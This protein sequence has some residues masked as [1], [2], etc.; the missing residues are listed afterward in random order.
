MPTDVMGSAAWNT[1]PGDDA[2]YLAAKCNLLLGRPVLPD[3]LEPVYGKLHFRRPGHMLSVAATGTGKGVSLIIPNLLSYRGSMLVIDPKGEN[4]W[5][6]AK[7][8]RE[9][10][11]NK[12]YIVD[13]WG[14]V[15]KAYG[16]LASEQETVARF[17][18]LSSLDPKA[19][20]YVDDVTYFGAAMVVTS[21]NA[22]EPH[23]D[24][25]A[26]EL[27]AGLIA[28]VIEKEDIGPRDKTLK[29]VRDLLVLGEAA[30]RA[31]CEHAASF[32]SKSVAARKLGRFTKDSSEVGGVIATARTQTKFLD[33]E[34]LAQNMDMSDFSFDE[35]AKGPTTVYL[36]LPAT[37]LADYGR[38]LRL[39]VS[40]AIRAVANY[41]APLDLPVVFMLDEF[42][43]VGRLDVVENAY[44]L[45]RGFGIAVWA[46]L[47]DFGQLQRDYPQSWRTFINNSTALT[48]YG[49]MDQSSVEEIS[50]MLGSKT[51]EYTTRSFSSGSGSSSSAS[52]V[53]T[54]KNW[55]ESTSFNITG[56]PL[57]MPDE[58][59]RLRED[60]CLVLGR[61]NPVLCRRL[62][63]YE[64][65]PFYRAARWDPH[66]S[67]PEQQ[68]K[69]AESKTASALA[70]LARQQITGLESARQA[71]IPCGFKVEKTR[72]GR[73]VLRRGRREVAKFRN[74]REFVP[75]AQEIL[76][77]GFRR[78]EF[79]F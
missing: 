28:Y 51:V 23:W 24:E 65:Y 58:V 19:A 34:I 30:L 35:L 21:E 54:S 32:G 6:T 14:E 46:F 5:V 38:W 74:E 31:V 1:Y 69:V 63:Y 61:H 53:S 78:L 70:Q 2:K 60:L 33:S 16:A 50:K 71:L 43:T 77:E 27:I 4:A 62:V 64:D 72:W 8:R 76:A 13:P 12:V 36:V 37:L 48:S 3:S 44:G 55:S 7:W 11:G 10:L 75:R 41:R 26:K 9:G 52:G 39:M 18:P 73:I 68:I 25:S 45:M 66:F 56:R 57:L 17:N 79:V 20:N 59:R 47:Q 67:N 49:S 40:M 22:K 42:G 29:T 15:N